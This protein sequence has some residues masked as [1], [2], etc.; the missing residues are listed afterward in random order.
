[1]ANDQTILG[2][3]EFGYWG[4]FDDWNLEIGYFVGPVEV[5]EK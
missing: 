3:F 4:L 5:R 2:Q 1:M